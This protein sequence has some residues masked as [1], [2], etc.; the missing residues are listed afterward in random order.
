[1]KLRARLRESEFKQ[2]FAR[3]DK[4]YGRLVVLF[5]SD[6]VPNKVGFVASKKVGGSVERNRARRLMREAF[7]KIEPRISKEKSFIL[8]A[9]ATINGKRMV[10]VLKDV[11]FLLRKEVIKQ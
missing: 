8:V 7:L 1:V 10:D 11:E 4:Y 5:V 3:S 6:A 9:R 2:I